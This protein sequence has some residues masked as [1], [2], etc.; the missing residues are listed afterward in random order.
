M[1]LTVR[2]F[3]MNMARMVLT[4]R[5]FLMDMARVILTVRAYWIAA[6]SAPALP[7]RSAR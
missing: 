4:V 2:A 7:D 5:A 3:F 6:A 1:V